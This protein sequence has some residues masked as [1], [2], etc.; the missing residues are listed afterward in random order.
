LIRA[1]EYLKNLK[2]DVSHSIKGGYSTT[3]TVS[4]TD[5]E[6]INEALDDRE[7]AK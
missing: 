6:H 3:I 5:L 7:T 1:I 2:E 4:T